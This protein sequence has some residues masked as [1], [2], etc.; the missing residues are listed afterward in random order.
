MIRRWGLLGLLF[1]L[2]ATVAGCGST[3]GVGGADVRRVLVVSL[4]G[5]SWKDVQRDDLPNLR[6]FVDHAAIGELSTRIGLRRAS[7]TDAYLSIGAGTRAIAPSVDPA[8]AVDPDEPYAGV[9][10]ADILLRRLGRVPSG[11]A[12]LPVG[13]AIERNERSPF[14]ARPGRLGDLL[15]EHGVGRA[16]IANADAAEGFVSDEPPPDGSYA[17]GAATALMGSDGLV[18]GGTVGRELLEEDPLAPFGRQLDKGAVLAAFDTA[19]PVE[20]RSVVLVEASD[21]S[22]A[23]AY[24]P[25]TR[26]AQ[27]TALREDALT[28]ADSLLGSLLQRIDPRHDAV[29][30]LS[31]V[32]AGSSPELAITALQAP[33]VPAGLLR[34][35]TT[36][37]DGYVQLADVAPTILDLLDLDQPDEI[38]GR[39]FE[40][41]DSGTRGRIGRLVDEADAAE[42]RDGLMPL[43]VPLV[44]AFLALVLGAHLAGNRCPPRLR[45]WVPAAAAG[46]L[47]VI[48]GTFLAGARRRRPR[49]HLRLPR[50]HRGDRR[51]VRG[52]H[53]ARGA[54]MAEAGPP[55]RHRVDHGVL[56]PRRGGRRARCS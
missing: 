7:T 56:R 32:A 44:I 3:R 25:R 26:G 11:V 9:A 33:G 55:G 23:A 14:G 10:T 8:V 48:P 16:V 22:R 5:V 21:L 20:G 17:R 36:R 43:V 15:D 34:S 54:A 30:V 51:C 53:C 39:A 37:R 49:L 12:Y 24:G 45:R 28:R 46:A 27:R 2:V 31:P 42:F 29:L 47:G 50:P 13:A 18:P 4:P 40:V 41:S 38:E 35:S 6:A 19:W 52:G 1:L